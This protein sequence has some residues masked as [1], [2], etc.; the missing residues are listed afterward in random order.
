MTR[1]I[2]L[3]RRNTIGDAFRRAARKYRDR[4]ALTFG[5][6][7]WSYEDLYAASG[8]IAH[9]LQKNGIS[10]GDRVVACGRNSDAYYLLWLACCRAGFVHVPVNYALTANELQ[11]VLDHCQA[12]ALITDRS[13]GELSP[14][15]MARASLFTAVFEDGHRDLLAIARDETLS[16]QPV[17]PALTS[18]SLAQLLY[19][20]GTTGAPKGAAMTHGALMTEYL[21]CI[22]DCDYDRNDRA[23]AAMPLYH[24][25][26]MHALTTPQ[27]LAGS[28]TRLMA[29]PEA[30]HLLAYIEQDRINSLF[31][32]P[33]VWISLLRHPAF[34]AHDLSSLKKI[35][36][37]AAIMPEPVLHELAERLPAAGLYN[38][39]GQS[40]IAP[41]ATVL[42]PEEHAARPTSAGRPVMSVETRIVDEHMNDLPPGERGEIV[43]RSPQLLA[44]YWG[45][46]DETAKAFQGG[47]F[48]SGDIGYM[49]AEGYLYIVDRIK[50]VINS[51]GVLV[52]SREVED[53]LLRH[54]AVSEVAVIALPDPKW[55][56][57]VAAVVILRPG[58]DIEAEALIRYTKTV[59]APFKVPK[60]IFFEE[61]LIRNTA[62]KVLK[63]AL[64]QRLGD[65]L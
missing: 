58:H 10:E 50:D 19:T 41:V 59:L 3:A 23:L 6:R 31:A 61:K 53:A 34:D 13:Q 48:H 63:R 51:G 5:D 4:A 20:S 16:S 17:E 15:G 32:P 22:A 18:N 36:Y 39:Y 21:A 54:P 46:E 55:I 57:I 24:S 1:E 62:G 33:T 2:E 56:E 7:V 25:A 28:W 8:R 12:R 65:H 45:Q 47:W 44:E 38:L 27:I 9:W 42:R 35:Y 26:Q 40:E 60:R 49:D 11:Y 37:G 52:A 14:D 29:T 43:H 64:R 30:P